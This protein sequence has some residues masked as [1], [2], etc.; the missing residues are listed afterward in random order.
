MVTGK[1][2]PCRKGI[3]MFIYIARQPI[4]D[5]DKK[6]K[7]YELL[8]RSSEK[9]AFDGSISG[10]KA[11]RLLLSRALLDFGLHT[12]TGGKKAYVNFTEPLILSNLPILL[13]K[14]RFTLEVLEDVEFNSEVL[15]RLKDYHDHGYSIAMDDYSGEPVED[16]VLDCIDIIKLD[17]M[18]T[19]RPER[20]R[21]AARMRGK[22]KILLAEKVET[23][24]DF[25]EGI[26]LGCKLFQGY[27]LSR[28]LVLKKETKQISQAS[29]GRLFRVVSSGNFSVNELAEIIRID[30]HL[31][32]KLL[33]KMRTA[34]YY[35]GTPVNS[36]RDAL[37]RMGMDEVRR[38]ITLLLM[39]D[40]TENEGEEQLF[41]ALV[42]AVFCE[43]LSDRE[44]KKRL[45]GD[46][47]MTGMFSILD[48]DKD[49][50]KELLSIL[51]VSDQVSDVLLFN[52]ENQV[53][54]LLQTAIWYE[55][56]NLDQ[57]FTLY[58]EGQIKELQELYVTAIKYAN[59]ALERV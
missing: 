44:G 14:E 52:K 39:Q 6:V 23:E 28:P 8:Y 58:K 59:E 10:D 13:D 18:K 25:E 36:V 29:T 42:R 11:T 37:V 50:L 34:R 40:L 27:Y 19:T 55:D 5:G 41:R 51:D 38:W 22:K 48:G 45:S 4:F 7:A 3:M 43:K 32:Y 9:N 49:E 20:A 2:R 53:S 16:E 24:E 35:R 56:F 57:L 30:A 47:F 21:I 12:I 33:Q 31:T 26:S 17:F 1:C 15:R 46:A 54:R